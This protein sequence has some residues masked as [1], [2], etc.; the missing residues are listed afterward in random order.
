M[1]DI[2]KFPIAWS[3]SSSKRQDIEKY[4]R[5]TNSKVFTYLFHI[6][7]KTK[8]SRRCVEYRFWAK[9]RL[10]WG[11][12]LL[13]LT[14]MARQAGD[15]LLMKLKTMGILSATLKQGNKSLSSSPKR[16]EWITIKVHIFWE[17]HKVLWNLQCRFDWHYIG[18]IHG[19][20]FAK[21]CG[22]PRIYEL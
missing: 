18:Q 20:D 15:S 5:D 21:F 1:N 7:F 6:F 14:K 8:I 10:I 19:G 9:F 17:G 16:M 12:F 13:Q 3:S 22:L 4:F 2:C 11:Y